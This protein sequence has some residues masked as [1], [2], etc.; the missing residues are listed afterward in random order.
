MKKEWNGITT[1]YIMLEEIEV[2][3]Q[4]RV[5]KLKAVENEKIILFIYILFCYILSCK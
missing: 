3:K 4:Y 1:K 2:N 5:N